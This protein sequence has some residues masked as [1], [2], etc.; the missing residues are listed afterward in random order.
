AKPSGTRPARLGAGRVPRRRI[1]VRPPPLPLPGGG[2]R[3][4]AAGTGSLLLVVR[5]SLVPLIVI[6][7]FRVHDL[8][9]VAAGGGA[10]L[11]SGAP[12]RLVGA[13][14]GLLAVH[15]LADRL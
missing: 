13:R 8:V 1:G 12:G 10:A 5:T 4:L 6:D 14:G 11:A 7:D 9:L 2:C 3:G 15:R